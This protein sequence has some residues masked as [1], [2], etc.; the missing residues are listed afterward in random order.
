MSSRPT[1]VS[2]EPSYF[3]SSGGSAL[4]TYDGFE[5]W[6]VHLASIGT[7]PHLQVSVSLHERLHHELQHTTPWGLLA[8]FALDLALQGKDAG[9][10][11]R[12]FRFCRSAS[13]SVHETY[14]TTLT[15][16]SSIGET[17]LSPDYAAYLQVGRRLGGDLP[18]ETGR[19]Q[20]DAVLRACM[21]PSDLSESQ[22]R[23]EQLRVKDLDDPQVR[24]DRR[25]ARV[26]Q[27]IVSQLP[28][29]AS[30]GLA[31]SPSTSDLD[32][33]FSAGARHLTNSG[34]PTMDANQL[35]AYTAELIANVVDLA[36]SMRSRISI[37]DT[38]ESNADDLEEHARE[39]LYLHA[40]P[41]PAEPVPEA[42]LPKRT[43]DFARQHPTLGIHCL[44]AWLPAK[45]IA[46]QFAGLGG[47]SAESDDGT[48]RLALL[49]AGKDSEGQPCA[50][51]CV[52]DEM[53]QGQFIRTMRQKTVV[54]TTA[55]TLVMS[56]SDTD[57]NDVAPLVVLVDG[58]ILPRLLAQYAGRLGL[59]WDVYEITGDR[60]LYA[61]VVR[62]TVL[63]HYL[64]IT[65]TGEAGRSYLKAWL[66]SL[67]VAEARRLPSAFSE[68][69]AHL[70]VAIRHVVESW[71]FLGQES[72]SLFDGF[73]K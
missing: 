1:D 15:A 53:D 23:F 58:P 22:R 65:I 36:P 60:Q 4:G 57:L 50:R 45:Q 9:R 62:L 41:L 47:W 59:M 10:F 63:T 31:E 68:W 51:L 67:N 17:S 13:R 7:D 18:W 49:A 40:D 26:S 24:P 43:L 71:W 32:P 37:D 27:D 28:S 34:I 29:P 35:R 21:S 48:P 2:R 66:E 20:I 61:I 12:L 25:L 39:R 8:R 16:F 38:R 11:E 55:S 64:W 70:D 56:P 69:R 42:D 46:R 30:F 54:I 44:V 73:G 3:C 5:T 14:A 52:I 6:S 33:Y 19:F 72:E